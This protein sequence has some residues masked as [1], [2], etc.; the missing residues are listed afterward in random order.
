MLSHDV[1]RLW[2]HEFHTI[3]WSFL[4]C[5][6]LTWPQQTTLTAAP[7]IMIITVGILAAINSGLMV[8]VSDHIRQIWKTLFCCSLIKMH[9]YIRFIFFPGSKN[10]TLFTSMSSGCLSSL[11]DLFEGT[12]GSW[13]PV[14]ECGSKG[15]KMPYQPG[16][17]RM[18]LE[19]G[20]T[21]NIC[22]EGLG[23]SVNMQGHGDIWK[24]LSWLQRDASKASV[25]FWCDMKTAVKVTAPV[26]KATMAFCLQLRCCC[27]IGQ[28]LQENM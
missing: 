27:K 28:N 13:H 16:M 8:M 26:I 4:G 14:V 7:L 9:S 22:T 21:E 15:S 2:K 17:L 5:S 12:S 1:S 11:L 24:R 18:K 20:T 23:T 6:S 25:P 10:S 19:T 3:F